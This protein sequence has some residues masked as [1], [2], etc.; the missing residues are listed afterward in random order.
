MA[1]LTEEKIYE[2]FGIE[3]NDAGGNEEPAAEGS[4]EAQQSA[5]G[6]EREQD[7]AEPAESDTPS[8][9]D[10]EGEQPPA[11]GAMDETTRRANAARRRQQ[12]Q[13]VAIQNAVQQALQQERQN[14]AAA[15][16]SI[17][18]RAG[19]KNTFTG[20][21]I[22]TKADFDAWESKFAEQR[23]AEEIK[24]G[25]MTPESLDRA[26]SEH[27]TVKQA[28]QMIQQAQQQRK[29]EAMATAQQRIEAELAEIRK[30]DPNI[31][32]VQDLLKS[33]KGQEIYQLTKKGIS[34][35]QAYY[36]ANRETIQQA[37]AESARA[38]AAKNARGK[39]HLKPDGKGAGTGAVSVPQSEMAM[40]RMF[41][42]HATDAE[43]QA[44]YNKHLKRK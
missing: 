5:D 16:E 7:V 12:E 11:K 32:T 6:G 34:L 18:T 23:R 15:L 24:A 2:A 27:P 1:E 25:K 35:S 41:M 39:E 36:L 26:I 44:H 38:Q 21:P 43:I 42:P 17:F 22:K 4:Q 37:M 14:Q 20:Q 19:L 8:E 13:Q 40:Y 29:A 3:R 10:E 9:D 33:Q 28:Q 30:T 31:G